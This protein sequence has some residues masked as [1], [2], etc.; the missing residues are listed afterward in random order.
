MNLQ[1][2]LIAMAWQANMT[3]VASMM[4]AAEVSNKSYNHIGVS[5]AF[6]PLS[7]HQNNPAKIAR[8]LR[9]QEYHS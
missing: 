5:D 9:V 1:M 3:R 7:H 2:D 8:L 4:F 6:H